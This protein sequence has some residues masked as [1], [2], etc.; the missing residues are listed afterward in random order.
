MRTRRRSWFVAPLSLLCVAAIAGCGSSSSSSSTAAKK[1]GSSAVP[2]STSTS[3]SSTG[4][5]SSASTPAADPAVAALVPAA[6]KSKGTLTVAADA[7]YAPNEFFASDGHTVIGMDADLTK[8]LGARDGPQ[9]ERR[10]RDVRQHHSRTGLEQV[11]HRRFVVHR[12]QGAREDGRLRRLLQCRRVVLH[13]GVRRNHDRRRLPTSAATRSPS[14]RGRPKRRTPGR[15]ARSARRPA[16]RRSACSCSPTR[17][18][19]TS[20]SPAAGPSSASPIRRLPPIRSRSRVGSSSSSARLRHRTIRAGDAQGQ[21]DDQAGAGR[22]RG[23][24][25]ERL[26]LV[27]PQALGSAVAARSPSRKSTERSASGLRRSEVSPSEHKDRTDGT[28]RGSRRPS[29]SAVPGGGSRRRS[30]C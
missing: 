21:R 19:R 23:A 25:E 13:E 9:G 15:R 14:R 24:D 2:P 11:R 17:T 3:S 27:D 30:C 22:A 28:A 20:R 26:V 4:T 6:I 5:T 12:Y 1:A 29:R 8:A 10:Q 7:S 18:A 16:R